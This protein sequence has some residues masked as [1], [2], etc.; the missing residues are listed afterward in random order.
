M[1]QHAVIG[2]YCC[3]DP[4]FVTM[5]NQYTIKMAIYDDENMTVTIEEKNDNP[6]IKKYQ[7]TIYSKVYTF[8][9]LDLRRSNDGSSGERER[10]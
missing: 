4:A 5:L 6:F 10:T 1:G 2:I 9:M 7:H 8:S 3:S